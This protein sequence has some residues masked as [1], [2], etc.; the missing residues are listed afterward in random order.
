M[1]A[2]AQYSQVSH[3]VVGPDGTVYVFWDGSTRLASLNSTYMPTATAGGYTWSPPLSVATLTEIPGVR[4]TVFR[5]N[6]Y[7]AAA[8]APNGDV[9]ATWDTEVD[10]T[11]PIYTGD[12]GC[13]YYLPG[14]HVATCHSVAVY[15]KSTD[16][17]QTWSDP[18]PVF[19]AGSRTGA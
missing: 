13:A 3:P 12:P 5:V 2:I 10:D 15:S 1:S 7:P 4:N 18:A 17:G 14:N 16:A 11:T 9:Y 8:A 6:S 19:G